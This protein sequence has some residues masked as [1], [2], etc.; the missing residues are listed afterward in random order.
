MNK[1]IKDYI[2]LN[3]DLQTGSG[4]A[5]LLDAALRGIFLGKSQDFIAL[6]VS[7][8]DSLINDNVT[9]ED[10]VVELDDWEMVIDVLNISS[11]DFGVSRR[12]TLDFTLDTEA[13][14]T[15]DSE[16]GGYLEPD[17]SEVKVTNCETIAN[18]IV[19][20]TLTDDFELEDDSLK[21]LINQEISDY[22]PEDFEYKILKAG[23]LLQL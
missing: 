12:F 21:I 7:V 23:L 15:V 2:S 17:Y 6:K 13:D 4:L 11:N 19:I 10:G 8:P 14:Y 22:E 9:D 3:E 16:R 1:Y 20:S 18:T 5:A